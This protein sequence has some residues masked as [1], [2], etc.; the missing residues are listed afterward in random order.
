MGI[1]LGLGS[2]LGDKKGNLKKALE[3]LSQSGIKIEKKSS[4]YQTKPYGCL[5]QEDFYNIVIKVETS[6]S[7]QE[8]LKLCQKIEKKMGRQRTI[9]WGPRLIDIDILLYEDLSLDEKNLALPH[10][11][12]FKRSF[13]LLPL[14]EIFSPKLSPFEKK[15][16]Q[17]AMELKLKEGEIKKIGKI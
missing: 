2:N 5:E 13:V 12:L 14:V 7:P 1:Y 11:G 8:L 17:K 4:L 3:L 6:L 15:L 16:V 9:R 10:P